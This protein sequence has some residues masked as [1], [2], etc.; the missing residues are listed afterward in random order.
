MKKFGFKL[1]KNVL[2][3]EKLMYSEILM[4]YIGLKSD[5]S[6]MKFIIFVSNCFLKFRPNNNEN[7]I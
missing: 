7:L 5:I 1:T 2:M 6:Y 4:V 3:I